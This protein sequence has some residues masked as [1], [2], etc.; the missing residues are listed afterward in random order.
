M[1]GLIIL[2]EGGTPRGT[3]LAAEFSGRVREEAIARFRVEDEEDFHWKPMETVTILGPGSSRLLPINSES[4]ASRNQRGV[5]LAERG[6]Y[7]Q[8]VSA[9]TETVQEE[10]KF[11][12]C[13]LQ[14]RDRLC[15][16]GSTGP[17]HRR[18]R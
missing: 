4:C 1:I 10:S 11:L 5:V 9:F 3:S 17:R 14:S 13:L 16:P 7:A 18:L 8:A 6:L 15:P 12:V 2:G